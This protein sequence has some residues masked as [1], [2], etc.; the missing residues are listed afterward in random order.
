MMKL[1]L[2]GNDS[3]GASTE[4]ARRDADAVL[5]PMSLG[6]STN[7]GL[8]LGG[9]GIDGVDGAGSGAGGT[10]LVGLGGIRCGMF[11]DGAEPRTGAGDDEV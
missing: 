10:G 7:G 11:D 2:G 4:L 8:L 3:D 9:G 5:S 1:N 6:E